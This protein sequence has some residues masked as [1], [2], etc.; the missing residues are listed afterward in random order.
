MSEGIARADFAIATV[1]QQ[2]ALL[3]ARNLTRPFR[4]RGLCVVDRAGA[5]I[6]LAFDGPF[7]LV[8]HDVLILSRHRFAS[9]TSQSRNEAFRNPILQG[10]AA[11][12]LW[13]YS[14]SATAFQ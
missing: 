10:V 8:R 11:P 4:R 13:G 14:R 1:Y 5:L 12:S 3:S 6:T 2:F 7:A 9:I